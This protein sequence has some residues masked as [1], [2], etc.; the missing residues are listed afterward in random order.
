[1]SVGVISILAIQKV[2]D[3]KIYVNGRPKIVH[4]PYVSG[5][6]RSTTNFFISARQA[7]DH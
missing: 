2:W 1:M 5:T 3:E 6:D 4:K 7:P